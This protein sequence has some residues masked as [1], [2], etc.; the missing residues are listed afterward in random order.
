MLAIDNHMTLTFWSPV[1]HAKRLPCMTTK[2]GVDSSS[3]FSFRAETLAYIVTDATGHP[4]RTSAIANLGNK[5][6]YY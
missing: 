3:H 5:I 4:A 2:F 6:C 1:M